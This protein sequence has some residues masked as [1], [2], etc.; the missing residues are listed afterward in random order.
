FFIHLPSFA[1]E[2]KG[3]AFRNLPPA[4]AKPWALN[5]LDSLQ[6]VG[7]YGQYLLGA[8]PRGW[9]FGWDASI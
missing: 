6:S 1:Q 9:F 4:T 5:P 2:S 3:N 8:G 7:C